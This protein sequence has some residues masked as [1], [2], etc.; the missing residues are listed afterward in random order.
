MNAENTVLVG[1][2]RELN[3]D[4]CRTKPLKR[5]LEGYFEE[6]FDFKVNRSGCVCACACACAP[7][8]YIY[9]SLSLACARAHASNHRHNSH[10]VREKCILQLRLMDARTPPEPHK[11]IGFFKVCVCMCVCVCVCVCVFVCACVC[12]CHKVYHKSTS[13]RTQVSLH[14]LTWN[15]CI[16]NDILFITQVSLHELASK[17]GEQD[18]INCRLLALGQ[19][20]ILKSHPPI[21]LTAWIDDSADL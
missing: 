21:K 19:A 11:G 15:D 1:G 18:T 3:C 12:V 16:M 6:N 2:E 7:R 8:A 9:I 13:W 5:V 10:M 17:G 20:E 4:S 14:E